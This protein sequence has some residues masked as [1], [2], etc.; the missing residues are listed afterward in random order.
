MNQ[1]DDLKSKAS[2]VIFSTDAEI[3][4]REILGQLNGALTDRNKNA[5]VQKS[6]SPVGGRG[7][8]IKRSIADPPPIPSPTSRAMRP[9][10]RQRE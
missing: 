8:V 7:V 5:P 6:Q 10:P 3:R 4:N 9:V 2:V 1:T